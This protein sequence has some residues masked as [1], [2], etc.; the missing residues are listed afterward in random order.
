[1]SLLGEFRGEL[2]TRYVKLPRRRWWR[3]LLPRRRV[4][5]LTAPFTWCGPASNPVCYIVPVGFATDFAS[6]PFLVRLVLSP[7]NG[8]ES[9]YGR[10]AV[11]HDYLYQTGIIPR[12]AADQVFYESMLCEDVLWPTRV[13]MWAAVRCFGWAPWRRYR[14]LEA[15]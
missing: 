15:A 14:R 3:W 10:A 8:I 6:V 9:D 7:T 12:V 1:M 4:S 5:I 2:E 13:S 11:I